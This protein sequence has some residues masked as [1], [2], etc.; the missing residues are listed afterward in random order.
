M[1]TGTT[2][3]GFSFE[4][5]EDVFDDYE[6]LEVLREIDE[7]NEERIVTMVDILLGDAQKKHLKEHVRDERGKVSVIRMM[8]EVT[9]IVMVTDS[10]SVVLV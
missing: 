10:S 5:E 8:E 2:S 6:L 4:L 9:E 7:G 3:S 1:I